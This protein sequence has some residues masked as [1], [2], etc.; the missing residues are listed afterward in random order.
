M[1]QNPQTSSITLLLAD[2]QEVTRSM[3]ASLLTAQG[4][5]VLQAIDGSSAIKT[6]Q[7]NTVDIA[8]FDPVMTPTDGFE[9]AKYIQGLHLGIPCILMAS[10]QT[11]DLLSYARSV[12]VQH[13]LS[14]PVDPARL[15]VLISQILTRANKT[16]PAITFSVTQTIPFSSEELMQRVIILARKNFDSGFGGPF[17]SVVADPNGYLIGEGV[18]LKSSRFDPISHAEVMAIRKATE[19]LQ[20]P[21]LEG[22]SIYSTSEPTRLARALIDSVGIKNIYFGLRHQEVQ[23]LRLHL[24]PE[25]QTT[26]KAPD[27]HRLCADDVADMIRACSLPPTGQRKVSPD[28]P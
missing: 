21:H 2:R 9:I 1:T 19:M 6:I 10:E 12:G 4:Y 24:N 16:K 23:E 25:R 5:R 18:N 3:V 8:I 20:Q 15:Q 13:I 28:R 22:C 26:P 14:K 7:N 27:V 11:S 17:A